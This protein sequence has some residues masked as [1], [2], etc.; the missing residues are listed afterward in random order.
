MKIRSYTFIAATFVALAIHHRSHAQSSALYIDST[1]KVGIGTQNPTQALDVRGNVSVNGTHI[2]YNSQDAVLNWGNN[3]TGTLYLRTLKKTGDNN[4]FSDV[5]NIRV[6]AFDKCNVTVKGSVE[7]EEIK[8]NTGYVTPKRGIIAYSPDRA[9]NDLFDA[10][11][12]GKPGTAVQGWAICNGSNGTPD[13]RGRFV[14]GASPDGSMNST[15][16]Q[17]TSYKVT[18]TGGEERHKLSIDEMPKHHHPMKG[19]VWNEYAKNTG[20]CTGDRFYLK[21][22]QNNTDLKWSKMGE[23]GGDAAHE[24]RP[25]YYA[26]LYIMKL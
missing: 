11:G 4:A 7:A 25:P 5:V 24:N 20:I 12:K 17:L 9:V 19:I 1:G 22:D 23:Q 10:S 6:P 14:V 8:D 3:Y 16:Q 13:L 15:S 26:L 21:D 2:I 18:D